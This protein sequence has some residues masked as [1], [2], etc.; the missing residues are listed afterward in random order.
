MAFNGICVNFTKVLTNETPEPEDDIRLNMPKEVLANESRINSVHSISNFNT[1]NEETKFCRMFVVIDNEFTVEKIIQNI[2][3]VYGSLENMM[4]K[5]WC[6][7]LHS[8]DGDVPAKAV[9]TKAYKFTI[10][11]D[12]LDKVNRYLYEKNY[13]VTLLN[14]TDEDSELNQLLHD[15]GRL[16]NTKKDWANFEKEFNDYCLEYENNEVSI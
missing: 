6:H 12:F 1:I 4:T 14:M 2:N 16:L 10:D 15:T 7:G 13:R 5:N 11:D 8:K 3:Y 9:S